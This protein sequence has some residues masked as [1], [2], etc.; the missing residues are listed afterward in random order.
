MLFKGLKTK[1]TVNL[2]FFLL[3]AILLTDFVVIQIVEKNLIQERMQ[4]GKQFIKEAGADYFRRQQMANPTTHTSAA[5]DPLDT[6]HP[7]IACGVFS[8]KNGERITIGHLPAEIKINIES[9]NEEIIQSR[10]PQY[11][12]FGETW[13]VFW[14]QNK[15]ATISEPFL[16]PRFA[17]AGTI[18]IQL[19]DIY[20]VLRQ[21]QKI[22]IF[23]CVANLIIL[24]FIGMLRLSRIVVRPIH[25]FIRLTE[26]LRSTDQFPA[27]AGRHDTEFAQLSNAIHRM[28][29]R[30]EEDKERIEK[31]L[32]SLEIAHTD[33]KNAQ[34]EMI[35]TEKLASI[36]RLS[37]GIAHEIGN[38]I[39]IVLGYLGLLKRQPAFKDNP[40]G[41]EYIDR[42]ESEINRINTIIRQLL[43]FSRSSASDK[44][45]VFMHALI[46][47]VRQ[48]FLHQPLM[49]KIEL[50]HELSATN[51]KVYA[52]YQQLRQV[53]INLLINAVD[54]IAVSSN[55]ETGK[56]SLQTRDIAQ[57]DANALNHFQTIELTVTDNGTGIAREE[58]DNIFDP[59]YTTKEPGKGTGLGLSVSYMIVEQFG[60]TIQVRSELNQG[61]AMSIYLQAVTED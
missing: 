29:R 51:D 42:A 32:H 8:F 53:L 10:E 54:S 5:N 39:G 37:A 15:Y 30:I 9:A 23:Y 11:L 44:Q 14:R 19:E 36:G 1:L 48:M 34:N 56:I 13:G 3:L 17:G 52:D 6:S 47:D 55:R 50:T 20:A 49:R 12:F 60:G 46:K 57:S 16:T 4:Q 43:D 61:T 31:S 2:A 18:V 27:D 22:I 41:Q 7:W 24:L 40:N 58:I 38:P 25:R 28:A 59:F 45:I 21:S 35:R 26:D 33:L